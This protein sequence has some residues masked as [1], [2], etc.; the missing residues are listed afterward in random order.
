SAARKL[1]G[2]RPPPPNFNSTTA[3]ISA[4]VALRSPF[5]RAL[6]YTWRAC[7]HCLN[8]KLSGTA[9]TLKRQRTDRRAF[10]LTGRIFAGRRG[11]GVSFARDAESPPFEIFSRAA[12]AAGGGCAMPKSARARPGGLR[13]PRVES[14][15][16]RRPL[17]RFDLF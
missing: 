9:R 6:V 12:A 13:R 3:E 7:P 15:K 4:R 8:L 14:P 11:R 2:R 17:P 1:P 16:G 5:R 10:E